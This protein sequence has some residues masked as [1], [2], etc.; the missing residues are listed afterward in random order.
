[1]QLQ[2]NTFKSRLN[3]GECQFGLWLG[4]P[5]PI[6]AEI[7]ATAGFDWLLIDAEHAPYSLQN[8]QQH[9]QAIAPYNSSALVRPAEGT[10]SNIKQLLDLGCQTLLIPMVENIEQARTLV[11]AMRYPPQGVRGLGTSMA[12]AAK[13]NGIADYA[14][15]AN[16]NACLI[17]QVETRKGLENLDDLLMVDGIDGVFIGPSDLSASLGYIGQPNH[18]DVQEAIEM[19]IQKIKN[20]EK[21][22]GLL[23]VSQDMAR[24]Y[25]T[26]GV[27]F[28]GVGVDAAL[29]AQSVRGLAKEFCGQDNGSTAGY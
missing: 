22:C 29:L 23:S 24:H 15:R 26:L 19:A 17:I 4:L 10:T 20:S 6:C 13:W 1:M 11:E 5:D 25:Q 8:I 16:E 2:E 7:S 27:D 12:R 9:L 28:I 18:P 3:S 14:Q 21:A